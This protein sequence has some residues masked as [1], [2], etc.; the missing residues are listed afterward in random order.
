[1]LSGFFQSILKTK[2]IKKISLTQK[3]P[4]N[5]N[6]KK[7]SQ[8]IRSRKALPYTSFYASFTVEAALV[9][10]VFLF[11]M[12]TI[13]YLFEA[14]LL[15]MQ[16]RDA[17]YDMAQLKARTAYLTAD[18]EDDE[19]LLSL[20][21]GTVFT[22][23]EGTLS[24]QEA[25]DSDLL[26]LVVGGASGILVTED[27][28]NSSDT[29]TALKAQCMIKLPVSVFG[30]LSFCITE[31]VSVRNWNGSDPTAFG[32]TDMVYVTENGTVYHEDR[33]CSY[34]NPSVKTVS[35]ASVSALRNSSGGRYTAC[36]YCGDEDSG[37]GIYYI[38]DYGDRW[39]TSLSCGGLKRTVYLVSRDETDL[40]ACSKCAGGGS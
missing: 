34:L 13:L 10:P 26:N 19:T 25:V 22:A 27:T 3:S 2:K 14:A 20:L 31:H 1:M 24:V 32:G 18:E 37:T 7:R 15:Q 21:E 33:N 39:H 36:E 40:P 38:T 9:L 5:P 11:L 28:E 35:A 12:L 16:I 30:T 29:V 8:M 23:L 17:L 4:K 6:K